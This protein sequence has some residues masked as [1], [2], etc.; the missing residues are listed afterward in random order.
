MKLTLFTVG[1]H[2][3]IQPYIPLALGLKQAGYDITIA[4]H[5]PYED[6][7]RGYDLDFAPIVGD[8]RTMISGEGGIEW[9]ET[10][11]NPLTFLQRFRRLVNEMM[12]QMG[13]DCLAAAEGSDALVFSSL[14][15]FAGTLVAEKL[16]IPAV[17]AYL[18]PV[19]TTSAFPAALFPS[20]PRTFPLQGRYNRLTHYL[21]LEMLWRF[22]KEPFH[23]LRTTVLG[24]P[25][26]TRSFHH[27]LNNPYPV[28][29]GY[30]RHVIP[31]PADW[32]E[33]LRVSGYW[34]LDD[35]V[36]EP[37]S[38]LQAFLDSGPKPVYVG[39][40][41]MTNRDVEATTHLMLR[42]IEKSGQRAVLLSGWAGIGN[43]DLPDSIFKLDY[44]PHSWL[45]PRVAAV[46]HHGGAGTTAAGLRAGVPSVL[47]P[48]FADQPFWGRR[49][50]ALGVGPRFIP[51]KQLTVDHLAYAIHV[52]ATHRPMQ[53][54]AA[55]LG[56]KIRAEDGVHS[57]VQFIER[58]LEKP[59][60]FG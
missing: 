49:V 4:T 12:E 30:S 42:A 56:E 22:F 52:A 37:S 35:A 38:T 1:S 34:F 16:S 18:Q 51:R 13:R 44:A 8:P 39:F 11:R 21:M 45:L 46:V 59:Q 53:R 20:L 48:H 6:F 23:H 40:G 50:N 54:R 31:K 41:S 33:R 26:E 60:Q 32:G 27:T 15:L 19:S 28:V 5:G 3:D 57:A 25:P 2:G 9:L 10:G 55:A 47:V 29:Y 17:G 14:G 7:V 43:S 24:L 58:V 36:W